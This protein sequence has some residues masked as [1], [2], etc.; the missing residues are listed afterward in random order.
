[1][2]TR[3]Q[4]FF[5]GRR[6]D[7]HYANNQEAT[8]LWYHDHSLGI[9]RLNVHAGLAGMYLVRDSRD[10]GQAGNPIGLPSGPF[11]LPLIIQD[12]MFNADGTM[13]FPPGP[14]TIWSPEFFGD[15]AVVNGKVWP[16]LNVARGVYR[17][18]IVNAR[19]HASTICIFQTNRR[20]FNRTDGALLN[21]PAPLTHLLLAPGSAPIFFWTS[22]TC[23]RYKDPM[24]NNAPAPFRTAAQS[25][26][27]LVSSCA[28]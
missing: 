24:K 26:A 20:C 10:T 13:A 6:F 25:A 27:G 22:P 28:R 5:P 7:Y 23:A 21:A 15:K 1:M 19:M 4:H 11:E 8:T 9:T 18:R 17:F 12:K 14:L 16:N 2:A 3:K